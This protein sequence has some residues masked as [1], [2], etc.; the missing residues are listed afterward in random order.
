MS[1]ESSLTLRQLPYKAVQVLIYLL[2]MR[3][4]ASLTFYHRQSQARVQVKTVVTYVIFLAGIKYIYDA[5]RNKVVKI[6]LRLLSGSWNGF[7]YG[8]MQTYIS[9]SS[10]LQDQWPSMK[11]IFRWAFR[12][13]IALLDMS[14]FDENI[15]KYVIV[16]GA[17]SHMGSITA[18]LMLKYGYSL[19]LIDPNL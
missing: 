2:D 18:N 3:I 11:Q 10:I 16:Y 19:L 15:N 14:K 1:D 13:K 8:A 17:C 6:V 7:G 9:H 4:D 12:D 5:I